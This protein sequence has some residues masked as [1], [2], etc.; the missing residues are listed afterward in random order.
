[1]EYWLMLKI[2]KDLKDLC[3]EKR[4]DTSLLNLGAQSGSHFG[5]GQ[6]LKKIKLMIKIISLKRN[7]II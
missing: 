7:I 2:D 4:L 6:P 5:R 1:M 3:L